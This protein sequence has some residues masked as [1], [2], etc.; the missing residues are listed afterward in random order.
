MITIFTPSF[1]D[2][3]DTNAQ[4]L[5]VK[6]IVPRLDPE[7]FAVT[8]FREGELVDPRILSRANTTLLPW[9]SRGNTWRTALRLLKAPPD[10][11]FF[12]REG[13]LDAVFLTERRRFRMK[14]SAAPRI[15]MATLAAL[16]YRNRLA[17]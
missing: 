11:Y 16:R 6:E 15:T 5:S 4:N 3:G 8:M 17:I 2:E 13:P 12:P 14:T 1:A 9:R 10:I 7:R